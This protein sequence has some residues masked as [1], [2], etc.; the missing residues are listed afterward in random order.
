[1]R[2]T[3]STSAAMIAAPAMSPR[4]CTTRRSEWAASRDSVEVALEVAGRRARHSRGGRGRGPARRATIRRAIFSSTMPAPA[5]MVSA[6]C[7]SI[8]SPAAM[9]AAMPPCAQAEDAPSPIGA[10]ASMVTGRGARRSAQN[11]PGEPAADDDDVV[12]RDELGLARSSIRPPVVP[13]KPGLDGRSPP[14]SPVRLRFA[15]TSSFS[16]AD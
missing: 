7:F 2:R 9:A 3:A 11:R 12:G 4:T 1:M 10:A 6:R 15:G 8:E 14:S 5:A 13:A 16:S